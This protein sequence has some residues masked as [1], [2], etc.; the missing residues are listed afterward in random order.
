MLILNTP[1]NSLGYYAPFFAYT[2]KSCYFPLTCQKYIYFFK[3]YFGKFRFCWHIRKRCFLV[4]TSFLTFPL[5]FKSRL[6]LSSLVINVLSQ[7]HI[8]I[9]ILKSLSSSSSTPHLNHHH[10]AALCTVHCS[11][12]YVVHCTGAALLRPPLFSSLYFQH[13]Q[14]YLVFHYHSYITRTINSPS[15][16]YIT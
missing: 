7:F 14:Q 8:I 4:I 11:T 3:R 10:M 9:I 1:E 12:V 13:I 15:C 16:L 2:C 6:L 5:S